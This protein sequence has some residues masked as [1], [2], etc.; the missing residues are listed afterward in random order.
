M[1]S[2]T[3]SEDKLNK[4]IED[5]EVLIEDVVSLVD[6]DEIARKRLKDIKANPSIAKS[7]KDLNNYL[8]K[9]RVKVE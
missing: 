8:K 9:R 4:V 7:E 2:I 1:A 5:V 6:Q 3:I